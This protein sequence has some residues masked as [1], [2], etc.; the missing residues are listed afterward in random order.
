MTLEQ[1]QSWR[2][3]SWQLYLTYQ[4]RS[5]KAAHLCAFWVRVGDFARAGKHAELSQRYDNTALRILKAHNKLA[6]LTVR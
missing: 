3:W 4:Q 5:D 1:Y 2:K 6:R